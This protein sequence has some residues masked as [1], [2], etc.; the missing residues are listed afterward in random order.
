MMCIV[1]D[2]SIS[3]WCFDFLDVVFYI[4][5]VA[6]RCRFDIDKVVLLPII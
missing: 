6:C 4:C 2:G 1:C 3:G 5:F